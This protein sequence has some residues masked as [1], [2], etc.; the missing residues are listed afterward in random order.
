M[1]WPVP[2]VNHLLINTL[3]LEAFQE[4]IPGTFPLRNYAGQTVRWCSCG[5]LL[6]W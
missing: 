4:I 2:V 1:R 6:E 5:A 3:V